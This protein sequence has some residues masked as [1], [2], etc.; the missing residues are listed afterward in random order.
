ME[1][2]AEELGETV[3]STAKEIAE[4]LLTTY[5]QFADEMLNAVVKISD[6]DMRSSS[7]EYYTAKR[8]KAA[9]WLK[10]YESANN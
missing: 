7:I 2:E 3:Q 5:V 10:Q 1:E 8:N 4:A 9:K 6:K